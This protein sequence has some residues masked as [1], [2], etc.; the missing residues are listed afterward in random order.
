MTTWTNSLSSISRTRAV[1][2]GKTL[3]I[4]EYTAAYTSS[5]LMVMGKE[6]FIYMHTY[7][8]LDL[9]F[10][11]SLPETKENRVN[12]IKNELKSCLNYH[13][14]TWAFYNYILV[15]VKIKSFGSLLASLTKNMTHKLPI[16]RVSRENL[17]VRVQNCL[18]FVISDL[19]SYVWYQNNQKFD[20]LSWNSP[21][22]WYT[23]QHF[24]QDR[25]MYNLVLDPE[26]VDFPTTL[27]IYSIT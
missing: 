27:I 5:H 23:W 4:T 1:W 20:H 21:S 19:L 12:Y 11:V 2:T 8:S 13:E 15:Y 7:G 26:Q 14:V 17:S 10:Y 18:K 24:H 3:R 9:L 16:W 22:V 25:I 6:A